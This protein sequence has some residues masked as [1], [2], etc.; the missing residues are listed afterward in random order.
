[1][2]QEPQPGEVATWRI[3][4]A[5]VTGI[6]HLKNG[7]GCDDAH[8]YRRLSNGTL[9]LAVADGAGSA[10]RAAEGALLA[11]STA[12]DTAETMLMSQDEPAN[13]EQWSAFLESVLKAVRTSIEERAT[14]GRPHQ[15]EHQEKLAPLPLHA[16]ATTILLA[17]LTTHGVAVAQIGDGA[18]IVQHVDGSLQALTKPEHGD[19]INETIFITSDDYLH[20][21]QYKALQ[22]PL[23]GIALLTDGLERLALNIHTNAPFRPFFTPLFLFTANA[24]STGKELQTFLTSERVCARTDDDKTL[25]LAVRV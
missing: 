22:V 13:H 12:L 17:I 6:G 11:V 23:Q 18:I 2:Q 3:Q 1:M 24:E 21:V 16:L 15:D 5:S 20:H 8:A 19:Y 9:I 14:T 25:V 7:R 4:G 10:D